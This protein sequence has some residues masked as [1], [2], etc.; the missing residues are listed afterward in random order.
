M[1]QLP[2]YQY[3]PT[4]LSSGNGTRKARKRRKKSRDVGIISIRGEWFHLAK[5]KLLSPLPPNWGGEG[6]GIE[7]KD[8][9]HFLNYLTRNL[10]FEAAWRTWMCRYRLRLPPNANGRTVANLMVDDGPPGVVWTPHATLRELAEDIR[11]RYQDIVKS[12]DIL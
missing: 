8:K 10:S 12:S 1:T 9:L 3:Y 2:A 5:W 4:T 11:Y 6:G 7:E